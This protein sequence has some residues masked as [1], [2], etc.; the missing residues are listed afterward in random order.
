MKTTTTPVPPVGK[1][2]KDAITNL[3]IAAGAPGGARLAVR[4]EVRMPAVEWLRVMLSNPRAR[5]AHFEYVAKV[6]GNTP[7]P[8]APWAQFFDTDPAEPEP[9]PD[10]RAV[11]MAHGGPD[12]C[13]DEEIAYLLLDQ[14]AHAQLALLVHDL[15]PDWWL[16]ALAVAGREY[17]KMVAIDLGA[18]EMQPDVVDVED[19][20]P[21]VVTDNEFAASLGSRMGGAGR[22][23]VPE[24]AGPW[25]WKLVLPDADKERIATI[26]YGDARKPFELRLHRIHDGR[27]EVEISPVPRKSEVILLA[28]FT[29]TGDNRTFT[30]E[31]PVEA[32]DPLAADD[33]IRPA[34]RSAP[35]ERLPD[36]AYHTPS[37]AM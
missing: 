33:D 16:D 37:T 12:V 31:V 30:L 8:R 10:P 14:R 6:F 1:D 22:G 29:R 32:R 5:P 2:I 23:K 4:P 34:T 25:S 27:A 18:A 35:C 36:A 21:T 11:E 9:L 24:Y 17:A 20:D 15:M 26:A 7:V 13:T 19:D 3:C 28:T